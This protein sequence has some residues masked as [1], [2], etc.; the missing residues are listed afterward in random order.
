MSVEGKPLRQLKVAENSPKMVE[1]AV[2]TASGIHSTSYNFTE[3]T[4]P[5]NLDTVILAPS[6]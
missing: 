5:Y 1:Q 6:L 4:V 2:I 3:G